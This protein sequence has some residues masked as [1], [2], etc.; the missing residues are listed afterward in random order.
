MRYCVL[1]LGFALV[2]V[3]L[4]SQEQPRF[5]AGANLVRVDAYVSHG[6][7]SITDLT[8]EDFVVYEDDKPQTVESFQV[9]KAGGPLPVSARR[10]PANVRDMEQQAADTA[11]L[12]TLFFDRYFVRL[13]GSFHTRKPLID[14]LDRMIGADDL[15]GVM[16]PEMPPSAVTYSKRTGTIERAVTD[17]WFWGVKGRLVEPTPLESSIASCYPDTR[18]FLGIAS[19]MIGRLREDAT[20]R[21]LEQLVVRLESL[22]P[23]RKFVLIFTEGW[24]MYRPDPH[25]ARVL[26]GRGPLPDKLEADPRTGGIRRGDAPDAASGEALTIQGCERLRIE[27]SQEDHERDFLRLLQRAN[28]ANVSFYP[29]D[30]RGLLVCDDPACTSMAAD[31]ARARER[32]R[33][34]YDMAAQTDGHAIVNITNVAGEMQKVFRDIGSYYLLGYYSTNTRLDGRFRRIRVE[35]KRKGLEVRSRP[36]YLAPTE[37]ELRDAAT[38]TDKAAAARVAVPPTVSRA[39]DSLAPT[40]GNL[41]ARI[42]ASG[43]PGSI[44]AIIEFDAATLKQPEWMTGGTLRVSFEPDDR[45][46]TAAPPLTVAIEPGQRSMVV[47]A[48]GSLPAGK[49]LVRAELTPRGSRLPLQVS[50]PV[51]VAP[52]EASIGGA[53]LAYRRGPSTGL[54]Y[55][56]TA[57]AR[58]R[59]TE[60]LRI[61]IPISGDGITATGRLLSRAG[62]AMPLAVTY[63]QRRDDPSGRSFGQAEVILSPLA[64][65]EYVLEVAFA[66]RG[67]TQTVAYGFRIVP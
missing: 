15:V 27:L 6:G 38:A 58:F 12:F 32:Q 23:E 53:A 63:Q 1:V 41:P 33:Y 47:D 37:A 25:L 48:P 17:T 66:A 16:T 60:R 61:E 20:L 40:R 9:V 44:G 7:E 4:H 52:A 56:P 35:V 36:G 54:A 42:Q 29:V 55:V 39:L 67:Q 34:L 13:E 5:R 21:A 30:S 11:R 45:N 24:P 31:A 14:T 43:G 49:Y 2:P 62:Q 64:A 57:D 26:E 46:G 22:R 19:A 28:R 59:R 18:E 8:P 50:T 10:D 3:F 51:D 65:G